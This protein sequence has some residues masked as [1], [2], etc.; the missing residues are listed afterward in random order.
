MN[1]FIDWIISSLKH[2]ANQ[3]K[4]NII[5]FYNKTRSIIN[6]NSAIGKMYKPIIDE[7]NS[8]NKHLKQ[9]IHDIDNKNKESENS[10]LKLQKE[11]LALQDKIS[12]IQNLL[13]KRHD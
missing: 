13:T 9:S 11:N 3:N 12:I 1:K 4:L 5:A 6:K 2:I 7:K 8:I 10:I